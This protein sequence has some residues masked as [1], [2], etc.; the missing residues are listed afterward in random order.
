MNTSL[1]ELTI[2]SGERADLME[3]LKLCCFLQMVM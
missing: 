1:E 2:I 3:Y